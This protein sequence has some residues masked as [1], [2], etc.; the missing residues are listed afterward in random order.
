M[1]SRF[2]RISLIV[3]L[4][5]IKA[6]LQKSLKTKNKKTYKIRKLP[7]KELFS[8]NQFRSYSML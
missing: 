7:Q 5:D 3:G 2:N 8:N 4:T 1:Y 6:I